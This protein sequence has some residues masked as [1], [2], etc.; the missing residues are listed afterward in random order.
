MTFA[1][2]CRYLHLM[3]Y[4]AI[5]IHVNNGGTQIGATQVA[6]YVFFH[7]HLFK[8][9]PL[10]MEGVSFNWK[11]LSAL[12][13][14]RLEHIARKIETFLDEFLIAFIVAVLVFDADDIIITHIVERCEE[15]S[16]VHITAPWQA[17][18]LPAHT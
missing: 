3:H 8:V 4:H 12:A 11:V 13:N 2:Q 17:R 10:H 5:I 18:N 9:L 7:N 1:R 6:T 14:I 15:F 16:P